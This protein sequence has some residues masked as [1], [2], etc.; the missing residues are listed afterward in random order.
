M[1]INEI[2]S[3][4]LKLKDNKKSPDYSE[5]LEKYSSQKFI[6]NFIVNI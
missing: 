1:S 4:I 3:E 2:K 5:I 6:E